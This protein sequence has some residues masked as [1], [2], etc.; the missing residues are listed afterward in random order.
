[1]TARGPRKA[2]WFHLKRL[3]AFRDGS[4]RN[5]NGDYV[6][7]LSSS[8]RLCKFRQRA[9]TLR[10]NLQFLNDGRCTAIH[11]K[12]RA[13]QSH[14]CLLLAALSGQKAS[15]R[16]LGTTCPS[17]NAPNCDEPMNALPMLSRA[18]Q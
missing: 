8:R 15:I 17:G 3:F 18:A 4:S 16:L 10:R 5:V 9:P 2:S 14:A 6:G 12:Y 13:I 7:K 1:M 11:R